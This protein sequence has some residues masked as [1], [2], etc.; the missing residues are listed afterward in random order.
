[1]N[2]EPRILLI[3]NYDSFTYNLVHLVESITHQKVVVYLNDRI[4]WDNVSQ[5]DKIILSPGPGLPDEAGELKTFIRKFAAEK[6]ML[7]VCLGHQAI[8]EVFGAQLKN[9]NQV[10]HG[11]ATPIDIKE[12]DTLFHNLEPKQWVGRYH[13]WVVDENTLSADFIIT[14]KDERGDIMSVRHRSL[15]LHGI[16]FHPESILTPNGHQMLENWIL[17]CP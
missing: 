3:D 12:E 17:P 2:L 6:S 4:E 7:G 15:P 10:C 16:Q 5:F 1:L 14:S 9:L 11:I 13:S 8:A